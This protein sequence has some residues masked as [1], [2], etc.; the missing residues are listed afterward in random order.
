MR[1]EEVTEE[2]R[3]GNQQGKSSF[4]ERDRCQSGF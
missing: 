2:G 3:E 1:I 4:N